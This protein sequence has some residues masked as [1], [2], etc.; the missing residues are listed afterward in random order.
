MLKDIAKSGL[1]DYVAKLG[2]EEMP[3]LLIKKITKKY[4]VPGYKIPYFTLAGRPTDFYRVKLLHGDGGAGEQK[5]WQPPN[6]LPKFYFPPLVDWQDVSQSE[7]ILYVT[8][9]EKKAACACAH[10]IPTIGL[11]GVWSWKS[12]Q[13]ALPFLPDFEL[14]SWGRREVRIVFDSDLADKPQ[15]LG[16]LHALART[17]A[18][19]GA[20]PVFVRLPT[21]HGEKVGLDDFLMSF[22]TGAFF[23]LEV[24]EFAEIAQLWALNERYAV[25][26]N[27]GFI[28]DLRADQPY[29]VNAFEKL[30]TRDLRATTFNARGE[31]TETG[32]GELWLAWPYRQKFSRIVYSPG[33]PPITDAGEF[34]AWRSWGVAPTPGDISLWHQLLDY[35]FG[36]DVEARKWFEQWC[37]Y[38]IQNPG[39]K[40]YTAV[41]FYGTQQGTGKSLVGL[42]LARLYGDNSS[43]ITRG[44]LKST[45]TEWAKNKQ[46]VVVEEVTGSD[47][48]SE[49][50]HLKNLITRETLTI[51]IKYQP[52][53]AIKDCINYF[54]TSQHPDA[55]FL[56]S[57]DR[58]F[59]VHE[60]P[61]RPAERG[62]YEAYDAWYR[63]DALGALLKYF[64]DDVDLSNFNPR[65]PAYKTKSKDDM[66]DLAY[67]D[68]DYW[69]KSLYTDPDSVLKLD[70]AVIQ[71]DLWD[72]RQLLAWYDQGGQR[73][74]HLV[75][76]RRALRRAGIVKTEPTQTADGMVRL[77]IVRNTSK[78]L[79]AEHGERQAEAVKTASKL[80]KYT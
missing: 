77:W 27:P 2:L 37:A 46:F 52:G 7:E 55:L 51:N 70:G 24:T 63:S 79:L 25:V 28:L 64:Q 31:Q 53:Y 30:I 78:W 32:V 59:F 65:A 15:I 22:G 57:S 61:R 67:S 26:E 5:Y 49:A 40:L 56:E 44:D 73:K 60:M 1:T 16:A 42:T 41:L 39:F 21:E 23:K 36:Q 4:L 58:R 69:C 18:K 74:T 62:F 66:I 47:K 34:N 68:L 75:A 43:L 35:C 14:I 19:L 13:A 11:G 38:P 71:K 48:R 80:S 6:T 12:K 10:G 3:E 9:G 29:T 20:K 54:M 50:D 76:L 17:L 33:A 8:E 45:Y 72:D